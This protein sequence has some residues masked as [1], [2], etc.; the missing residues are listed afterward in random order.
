VENALVATYNQPFSLGELT[1]E[2]CQAGHI[3]GSAQIMVRLP[4][5]LG[6]LSIGYTGDFCNTASCTAGQ[7]DQLRC[8]IL[9]VEATFGKPHYVFPSRTDAL[10]L[11]EESVKAALGRGMT[12][13]IYAYPLGK[14]QEVIKYLDDGGFKVRAH[15]AIWENCRIY[16]EHGVVFTGVGKFVDEIRRGEILVLPHNAGRSRALSSVRQ[17]YQIAVTGWAIDSATRYRLGV[18]E[19][20]PLS[21]HAD[22]NGL[23]SYVVASGAKKV[24]VVHGFVE[25]FVAELR[26]RG[27]DAAPLVPPR[28]MKLPLAV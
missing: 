23:V 8:D 3:L 5:G 1:L 27:V 28:Q 4:K 6:G 11:L 10:A 24:F 7:A 22:F 14:S 12:P 25:E 9:V 2:L 13:V 20:V 21:D 17:P 26:E 19:A 18:D 16:G 15:R